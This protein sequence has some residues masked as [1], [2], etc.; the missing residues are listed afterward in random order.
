MCFARWVRSG[1]FLQGVRWAPVLEATTRAL[2]VTL[3]TA[4]AAT[5]R[6]HPSTAGCVLRS[7]EAGRR[8]S[9][10]IIGPRDARAVEL[11]GEAGGAGDVAVGAVVGDAERRAAGQGQ[12]IR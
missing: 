6:A 11:V 9:L 4:P 5:G 1:R 3:S 12:V 8:H 7:G 2:A 10:L